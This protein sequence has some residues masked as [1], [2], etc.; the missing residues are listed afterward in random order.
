MTSRSSDWLRQARHSLD[1]SR[2]LLQGDFYDEACFHAQQS[3]E[4]GVKALLERCGVSHTGHSVA[5]A[6][7][8]LPRASVPSI[9]ADVLGAAQV[10]DEYYIAPRY[11]DAFP[12][13]APVDFFT[14][15]Q[16]DEAVIHADAILAFVQKQLDGLA[17][18]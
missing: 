17:V 4:L 8:A 18:D 16:A 13:G 6:L 3:A 10:V 12:S 2:W 11:P 15:A 9:P 5:H 14:R 1:A 7:H